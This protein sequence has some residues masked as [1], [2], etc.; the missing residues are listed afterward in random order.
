M[1]KAAIIVAAV[2]FIIALYVG[3]RRHAGDR[4]AVAEPNSASAMAPALSLVDLGGNKIET[5]SYRGN[6]VLINFWA[7]WCTPCAQEIPQFVAFQDRYRGQGFQILGISMEDQESALR[8]FYATYKMNYPVVIGNQRIAQDY[9]GI[10]GL[11]TSFLVGRDGRIQQKY[12]GVTDFARLEHD[13]VALLQAG[14]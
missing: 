11:P 6:V 7:A 9:G 14:K 4:K 5:A 12:A 13:I 3:T 10:L 2:G 1:R 8:R